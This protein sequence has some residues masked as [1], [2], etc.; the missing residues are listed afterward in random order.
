M[1]L[2]KT[3]PEHQKRSGIRGIFQKA[4]PRFELGIK[5]LQSSALPLGHAAVGGSPSHE[6][7]R[8]S[9][10][11]SG[12]LVV[13]NGHGEDL[14]ARRIIEAIH[15]LRPS[16]VMSVLPLVGR[17]TTFEQAVQAGWLKRVGPEASLPSGGFSNQSLKG[18]FADLSSGLAIMSWSQWRVMQR[19]VNEGHAVLAVGDLLPL[20]MA[21]CSGAAFAFIGTPKSDYTWRSGPGRALSDRYHR[22]KGSEWDP[23]EWSLMR[24]RHCRFV[25]MRDELTAR[26]LR[27]HGVEAL[28]PGNPMMDGLTRTAP[29]AALDRCRRVVLLCGSRTPEASRNFCH[30]IKGLNHVHT[31]GPLAVLVAVGKQP[32]LQDL[33][34][35][36]DALGYRRS[37]SPSDELGAA[38]CWVK[39][40]KL[41]LIGPGCFERWAGWAEAAIATAGTA[42]EQIV[43]LGIPALSLPGRG[44]QF[45]R[46]FAK[47]QSRLLGGAVHPCT[48]EQELGQRLQQLLDEPHLGQRMGRIGQQRMGAP[49][50]S[51]RLA[52]LVLE[53]LHGY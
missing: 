49:G 24:S 46:S 13:C 6:R 2:H 28:A 16:L 50:G 27:R 42:T 44:P 33:E 5:D 43:G 11:H 32:D 36:L 23:W 4:A 7:D 10:R 29:P 15:R 9:R 45:K 21:R 22:L 30:L 52:E 51:R 8:I 18:L 14:I 35:N 1:S 40:S 19:H 48:S 12:L 26:G 53:R 41:V 31:P 20:L 17:G 37:L 39:E 34:V 25:A 47:R 3:S 38:A